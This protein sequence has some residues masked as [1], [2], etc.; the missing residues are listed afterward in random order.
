MQGGKDQRTAG[1]SST[2]GKPWGSSEFEKRRAGRLRYMTEAREM[3]RIG[4]EVGGWW[5][6]GARG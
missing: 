3:L 4:K 5:T 2:V 1:G 6:V